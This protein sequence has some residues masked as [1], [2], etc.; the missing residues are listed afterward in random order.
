[1]GLPIQKQTQARDAHA[2][3]RRRRRIWR[4]NLAAGRG[5]HFLAC[6]HV[7]MS[8]ACCGLVEC[9]RLADALQKSSREIPNCL[10]FK[11]YKLRDMLIKRSLVEIVSIEKLIL[12]YSLERCLYL[13]VFQGVQGIKMEKS[14][15]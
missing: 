4:S 14:L 7:R 3:Q 11:S 13:S 15:E 8:R 6:L 5:I 12:A 10:C 1:M 2:G 9:V